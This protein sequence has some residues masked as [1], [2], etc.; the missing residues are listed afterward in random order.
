V[1]FATTRVVE[2]SAGTTSVPTLFTV[3]V[4]TEQVGCLGQ[5]VG[6]SRV[7]GAGVGAVGA[8]TRSSCVCAH[9]AARP[10]ADSSG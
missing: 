10:W 8:I 2:Y 1:T 4:Q 3:I 9:R 6:A 7:V 5:P